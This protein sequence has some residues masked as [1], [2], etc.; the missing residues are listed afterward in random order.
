[1][2]VPDEPSAPLPPPLRGPL[3]QP[4]QAFAQCV[5]CREYKTMPAG[6]LITS[7]APTACPET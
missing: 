1:M 5:D 6:S 3:N 7:G 4:V 2:L